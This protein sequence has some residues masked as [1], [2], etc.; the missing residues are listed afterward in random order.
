MIIDNRFLETPSYFN[1]VVRST[2]LLCGEERFCRIKEIA[3]RNIW[4]AA[5]C[6]K[7]CVNEEEEIVDWLIHRCETLYT[8]FQVKLALVALMELGEYGA[9]SYLLNINTKFF[10]FDSVSDAFATLCVHFQYDFA[11][12]LFDLLNELGYV[13]EVRAFNGLMAIIK[14]SEQLDGLMKEM[15]D[16]G[17]E[18]DANSY[19]HRLRRCHRI[20][21]AMPYFKSFCEK[22]DYHSISMCCKAYRIVFKLSNDLFFIQSVFDDLLNKDNGE[23]C[24]EEL[25]FYY[26]C[27]ALRLSET[28]QQAL[29]YYWEYSKRFHGT[30]IESTDKYWRRMKHVEQEL[31]RVK[32]SDTYNSYKKPIRIQQLENERRNL[33]KELESL[34]DN[35]DNLF[36]ELGVMTD[37]LFNSPNGDITFLPL[38]SIILD[39][40][41]V[42]FSSR[43]D[44]QKLIR[45]SCSSKVYLV[46]WISIWEL[47]KSHSLPMP[48][49]ILMLSAMVDSTIE[50]KAILDSI[51]SL[52]DYQPKEIC[53]ALNEIEDDKVSFF[54]D[55]LMQRRYRMNIIIF[56]VFIK[57]SNLSNAFSIL[58]IM[59]KRHLSPDIQS[60]QPLLRKWTIIDEL[61]KIAEVA[62]ALQIPADKQVTNAIVRRTRY[63]GCIDELVDALFI[64]KDRI[65]DLL[66]DSWVNSFYHAT[67]II[68]KNLE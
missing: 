52:N 51:L 48:S 29:K 40:Y 26:S 7:S 6:K 57:K 10:S 1:M 45:Y 50:A 58:Y 61:F 46:R 18:A 59:Q 56:N 39:R 23:A 33:F 17:V 67:N 13:M 47:L 49:Q 5:R 37:V 2:G 32:T 44:L 28:P 31:E 43:S 27:S 30:F 35:C 54:F 20:D 41:S 55:Y 19:L 63:L 15:N 38:L 25:Y 16:A 68:N 8:K 21:E 42:L 36:K 34:R 4:L 64:K 65:A 14:D 62:T 66:D 60:I 12:E 9:F 11:R 24:R 53:V 3:Q 22:V